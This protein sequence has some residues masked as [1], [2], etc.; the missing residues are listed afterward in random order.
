MNDSSTLEEMRRQL[1]LLQDKLKSQRIVCPRH[2]TCA[3]RRRLDWIER[4]YRLTIIVGALT[5]VYGFF[6][7][8]RVGLD[9]WFCA[10]TSLYMW[11][12]VGYTAWLRRRMRQTLR[13]AFS[14][15]ETPSLRETYNRIA[16]LKRLDLRWIYMGLPLVAVWLGC[17]IYETGYVVPDGRSY[18]IGGLV[19]GAIGGAIGVCKCVKTHRNY[20]RVLDELEALML[21]GEE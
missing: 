5:S 9:L 6:V 21:D 18:M 17:Y 7:F 10:F 8:R 4:Y 15:C 20:R 11:L 14:P 19:G 12:A 2:L 16:C 1:N 3:M 13:M